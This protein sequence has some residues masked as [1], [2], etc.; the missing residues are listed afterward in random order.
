MEGVRVASRSI[1]R[2]QG[3]GIRGKEPRRKR[4]YKNIIDRRI[5]NEPMKFL[6]TK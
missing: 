2:G 5:N 1:K 6:V 4:C 3:H